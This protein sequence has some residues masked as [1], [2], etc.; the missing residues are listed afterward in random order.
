MKPSL[1]IENKDIIERY[2]ATVCVNYDSALRRYIKSV[3]AQGRQKSMYMED[4]LTT[5]LAYMQ[6]IEK[7]LY[8]TIESDNNFLTIEDMQAVETRLNIL[9]ESQESLFFLPQFKDVI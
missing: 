2:W 7:W 6:I 4:E 9:L 3:H 1:Y 5:A 8:P